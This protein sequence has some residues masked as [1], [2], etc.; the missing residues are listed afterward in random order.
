[1]NGIL[2]IENYS[3][4]IGSL[5]GGDVVAAG[6][7]ASGD[8]TYSQ[9]GCVGGL[10][11]TLL[12]SIIHADI[13]IVF[14]QVVGQGSH[15]TS[16]ETIDSVTGDDRLMLKTG[17]D[18]GEGIQEVDLGEVVC[19]SLLG[20]ERSH[21][22]RDSPVGANGVDATV[23]QCGKVLLHSDGRE[24]ES[25]VITLYI[26]AESVTTGICTEERED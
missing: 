9:V 7:G 17:I 13:F 11:E 25:I 12:G 16:V 1:V 18:S 3:S 19:V 20:L 21:P 23:T 24:R 2:I 15:Y 26:I 5:V 10:S 6:I 22:V 14:V 4:D 8:L